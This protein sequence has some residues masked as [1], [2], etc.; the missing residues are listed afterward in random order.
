MQTVEAERLFSGQIGAEYDILRLAC[1]AAA[2]MSRRV[3]EAVAAWRPGRPLAV[4]EIGCGT[5]ITTLA[6]LLARGDIAIT[7]VDNEPAMLAQARA[8]LAPWRGRISLLETD[9]LSGLQALPAAS[10]D[11]VASGYAVHNF[12]Q[13][14]RARVLEEVYR[15][16]KPGGVFVN[17]DRYALDDVA[18]H[19]RLVQEEV[20][21]WF[22]AFASAGRPD[23]LEQWIVH[24]FSDESEDHVMRLGPSLDCLER[25]G[26]NPVEARF[27]EG[28]N[29]LLLAQKPARG[30]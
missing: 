13:G 17:G 21:H 12:L 5:G 7:A 28:V 30:G 25:I 22:K 11:V 2:E 27:R 9:A 18:A 14:Y 19:T 3:G 16:L 10:V 20:R 15:V 6:L 29:T 1:P 24:L 8:N 26:F 23:L 4:F